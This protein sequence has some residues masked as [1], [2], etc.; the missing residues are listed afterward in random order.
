VVKAFQDAMAPTDIIGAVLRQQSKSGRLVSEQELRRQVI[1]QGQDSSVDWDRDFGAMLEAALQSHD[2]L[3]ELTADDGTRFYYSSQDM[4]RTYAL[5]LMQIQGDPARLIA[6]VVRE[7]SASYPRP[8]SL[9][10]FINQPFSFTHEEV[11]ACLD[12][13]TRDAEY[14]DIASTTTSA[15]ALYLY[16]TLHL[17]PDHASM[18]AEW[19]DVGQFENP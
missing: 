12:R 10:I 15:S 3:Q 4:S 8:V 6:G 2:D 19:I 13:M 7:N 16:S 1:E 18:L 9:D 14:G 11:L 17:E 5:M